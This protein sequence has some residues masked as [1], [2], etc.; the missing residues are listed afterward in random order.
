MNA[1]ATKYEIP[2]NNIQKYYSQAMPIIPLY[3]QDEYKLY[4]REEV[5]D[6][7]RHEVTSGTGNVDKLINGATYEICDYIVS[8][9]DGSLISYRNK[10]AVHVDYDF[11]LM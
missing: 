10:L 4:I 9:Q 2:L 7:L 8:N 5:K 6:K 11:K 3:T 1:A